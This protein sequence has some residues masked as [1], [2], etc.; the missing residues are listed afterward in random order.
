[1]V[2]PR[3]TRALNPHRR[4]LTIK[5]IRAGFGGK[6]RL[7]SLKGSKR[8][9]HRRPKAKASNPK[10][11][12]RRATAKAKNATRT[13]VV[14]RTKYKTRTR[15]KKVYVRSKP[16]RRT[17]S[18]AKNPKRRRSSNPGS[19]L[20]TMSPVGNPYRKRRKSVAK[21]RRKVSAKG[22]S[23]KRNP[24]RRRSYAKARRMHRPRSRNPFGEGSTSLLKK[25]FGVFIGFSA[26]KKLPPMLGPSM[27]SSAG[28]TLLSTA[29]TAGVLA[30]VAKKFIPGPIAEGVLWGGVG[31]VVNM[32]WNTWAPSAV[33]SFWPGVGDFVPGGFPLPQGPVR[34]AL[35]PAPNMAPNGS[36]VN[37]GAFGRAW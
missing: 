22:R 23:G 24:T 37:V 7:A 11:R 19:Y 26:A 20:L 2:T 27:N 10:K 34:Y 5:Q 8:H 14:Y 30:W 18:K 15:T 29:V 31:G 9:A 33:T 25:G 17:S 1:M 12:K 3:I 13:R 4:K 28:M 21:R 35:A 6:R 16:R 36:Q 32:A